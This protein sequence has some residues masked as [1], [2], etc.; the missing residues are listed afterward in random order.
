MVPLA[1]LILVGY[2]CKFHIWAIK[3]HGEIRTSM[4]W[5]RSL[6]LNKIDPPSPPPR[7]LPSIYSPPLSSFLSFL[8]FLS[9]F[10]SCCH[11]HPIPFPYLSHDDYHRHLFLPPILPLLSYHYPHPTPHHHYH[12]QR[13]RC[14]LCLRLSC[15]DQSQT[16][17]KLYLTGV[18][19][20]LEHSRLNSVSWRIMISIYVTTIVKFF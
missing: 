20:L 15:K 2:T 8:S 18:L 17:L 11:F 10:L 4:F 19:I 13:S 14:L 7:L 6:I 12:Y 3:D 1:I 9:S 16:P 5:W